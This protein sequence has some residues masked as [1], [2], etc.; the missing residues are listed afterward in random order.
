MEYFRSVAGQT[1]GDK[2]ARDSSRFVCSSFHDQIFIVPS[3][4]LND[5]GTFVRSIRVSSGGFTHP[6]CG[7]YNRL[8]GNLEGGFDKVIGYRDAVFIWLEWF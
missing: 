8:D 2:K 1:L 5:Y 7:T 6:M 3:A 4:E